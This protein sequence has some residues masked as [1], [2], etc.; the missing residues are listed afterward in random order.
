MS[1][2]RVLLDIVDLLTGLVALVCW[3]LILVGRWQPSP[4]VVVWVAFWA[5]ANAAAR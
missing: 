2:L 5:L 4:R 1:E 3:A